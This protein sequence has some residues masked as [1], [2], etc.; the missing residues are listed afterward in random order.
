VRPRRPLTY[1]AASLVLVLEGALV[2]AVL[3]VTVAAT[4]L[5]PDLVAL[6]LSPGPVL[7]VVLW[8]LGILIV[9]RAGKGL[10]WENRGEAPD[11]QERPRGH[12]RA[13]A[14]ARAAEAGV[15]TWHAALV[16]AAAALLTLVA[17]VTIERSG[18]LFFGRQGLSG[19]L[20]GATV[21]AA[22]TALPEVSTGLTAARQGD[23]KLAI[24]DIFGGNAFLPVLFLLATVVSGQA[25]LPGAHASDIYLTALGGLLTIVY[26]TGL[27]LRPQRQVL[28]MG[29]DSLAVLVLYAI[30]I[31]GLIALQ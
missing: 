8:V 5:P 15:A 24:G 20:F 3:L 13:L 17:G 14:E 11:G 7:I 19:V 6:R 2:L 23:Y 4:Q 27:V 28:R 26:M 21:L 1:L 18:E 29:I 25:V 9:N 22:A 12:A 31:A 30:G 16:F 10:P